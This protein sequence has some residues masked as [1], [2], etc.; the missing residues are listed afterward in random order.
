MRLYHSGQSYKDFNTKEQ[1]YKHVQKP[2]NNTLT[3]TFAF[4]DVGTLPPNKFIELHF[5]DC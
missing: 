5:L 2:Q 3:Q 4:H 1:I